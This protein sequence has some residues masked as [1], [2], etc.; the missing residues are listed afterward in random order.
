MEDTGTL[1]PET[2]QHSSPGASR[3]RGRW[4]RRAASPFRVGT[5]L[6]MQQCT[7]TQTGRP[8]GWPVQLLSGTRPT[9]GSC[10]TARSLVWELADGDSEFPQWFIRGRTVLIPKAGCTGEWS[11]R[12][13]GLHWGSQRPALATCRGGRAHSDRA[14]GL[15]KRETW[16]PGCLVSNERL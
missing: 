13:Q 7:C 2:S 3:P 9:R 16:V 15:Q 1:C 8:Q 11:H 5:R 14:K 6:G 10:D 4:K 12:L